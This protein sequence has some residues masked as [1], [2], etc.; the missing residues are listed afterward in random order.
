VLG[1]NLAATVRVTLIEGG[2]AL[3]ANEAEAE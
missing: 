3:A 2:E 1:T